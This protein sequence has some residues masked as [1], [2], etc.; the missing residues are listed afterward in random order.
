MIAKGVPGK[1]G[2]DAMVLMPIFQAV[3]QDQIWLHL[4]LDAFEAVLDLRADA[5]KIAL[6]VLLDFDARRA[7]VGQEIS[8]A[9]AR[10]GF[11]PP[12]GGE[13]YPAHARAG[14]LREQPQ[15]RAAAAD[16][17]VVTVRAQ[18]QN[19]ERSRCGAEPQTQ[20]QTMVASGMGTMN[21]AP[22]SRACASCFMISSLKFQGKMRMKSGRA[23]SSFSGA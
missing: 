20:H 12:G 10:L 19:A 8:G 13:H 18:A 11:S 16:L 7:G 2:D 22:Q 14:V 23:S 3:C 4:G 6:A 15:Q 21:L 17:D 9:G 5:R 1:L